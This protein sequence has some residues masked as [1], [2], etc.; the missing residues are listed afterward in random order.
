M[1]T[2]DHGDHLGDHRLRFKGAEQY[3]Q[4]TR[5]PFIWYDPEDQTHRVTNAIG[6]T[7]DIGVTILERAKIEPAIGMQGQSLF[8]DGRANAFIQ[9]DHQ[10]TNPGIGVG[11][12]VHTIRS[13]RYRLSVIEGVDWGEL[14]DLSADPGE[15][16]NLWDDP[17]WALERAR[18]TEDLARAEMATVDRAPF[19]TGQA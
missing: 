2:T 14:Y 3:E 12:R 15:F 5:V 13:P 16:I 6:Q 1:F 10:K 4:I 19:P 7:H 18:L 11:P 17:D 8:D 9:Y